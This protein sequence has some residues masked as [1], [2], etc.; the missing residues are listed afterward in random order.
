M[1]SGEH[2]AL[3]EHGSATLVNRFASVAQGRHPREVAHSLHWL[4]AY[5]PGRLDVRQATGGGR[6]LWRDVVRAALQDREKNMVS[7]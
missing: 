6:G 4:T 7:G 5:D 1:G 3:T 2:P